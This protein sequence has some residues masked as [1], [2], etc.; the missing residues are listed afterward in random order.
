MYRPAGRHDA[1]VASQAERNDGLVEFFGFQPALDDEDARSD[2]LV[3]G[4][5]GVNAPSEE[6]DCCCADEQQREPAP[7][8]REP[9]LAPTDEGRTHHPS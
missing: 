6:Q 5:E 3:R 1:L 9:D 8:C 4:E 2:R 7:D